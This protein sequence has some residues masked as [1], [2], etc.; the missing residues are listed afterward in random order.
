M[1]KRCLI[2]GC[3]GFMGSY[4][5]DFLLETG[6]IIYGTV[7]QESANIDHIKNSLTILKCDMRDKESVEST[8]AEANPDFVF[9]LAAQSLPVQSWLDPEKTFRVNVSGTIYLLESI[10]KLGIDPIIEVACS[11]AEY[12]PCNEN[13]LPIKEIN[14]LQPSSPYGVSKLAEDMFAR[15]Y[16]QAYGVKIIRLRPFFV[17]G[18]RKISDVCSDFANGIA[19]IEVGKR[20]TLNV[21]NLETVRD[22]IDVRDTVMAMWLLIEKGKPGEVYNICT[23]KGYKIREILEML[24]SLSSKPIKVRPDP[25]LM[26]SFDTPAIIGDNSKLL[27]LGWKPRNPIERTLSE[28]L[29]YWREEVGGKAK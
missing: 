26:R 1:T 4:L 21:G 27:A 20:D 11:S 18:P 5:A 10:R 7:H 13:T 3:G 29:D 6:M 9:H 8:V 24:I 2:T 14:K 22:F 19:E 16:W 12:E 15:L 25:H 23:G 28:M 17:I